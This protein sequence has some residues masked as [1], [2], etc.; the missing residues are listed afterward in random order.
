MFVG[1]PRSGHSLVGSL[2]SAHPDAVVANELDVI[3]HVQLGF[4][5]GQIYDLIMRNDA[6]F[7]ERGR[8]AYVHNYAVPGQWQ[9]R[10]RDLRVIGDKKGG[11]STIQLQARPRLLERLERR[12]AVPVR[13]VH[14]TRNPF[15]NVAAMYNL[16]VWMGT[17][18][19]AVERYQFLVRA[20]EELR[21]RRSVLDL[22][23]EQLLVD[24]RGEL[25]RLCQFLGIDPPP[26]YLDACA[27]I[28]Y[29][30]PNRVRANAPWTP[31]LRAT[32]ER[33]IASHE[34][35]HGYSWDD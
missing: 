33:L 29:E 22:R 3:R 11:A 24:P 15:D 1:Y 23:H 14:V 30:A 19:E 25:T 27:S 21:S 13:L 9:G 26:D 10:Y 17:F 8:Q 28:L 12:L 2:L 35:L 4:R 20:V 7:E 16:P 5:R 32:V 31:D 6:A 18:A 34:F